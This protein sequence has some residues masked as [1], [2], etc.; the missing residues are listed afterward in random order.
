MKFLKAFVACATLLVAANSNAALINFNDYSIEGF[1]GQDVNGTST[2]SDFGLT[3]DLD[4]NT[5]VS[6]SNAFDFV[7][8]PTSVLYF[9][10]EAVGNNAELYGIGFDNDNRV[11]PSSLFAIGGTGNTRANSLASYQVGDGVVN[12]AINVGQFF[13]GSFEKMIFILDADEVNN[14]FASFSD[15]ELCSDNG[16]CETLNQSNVN[17]VNSPSASMLF[18]MSLCLL[19]LRIRR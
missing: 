12:F 8:D 7:I 3:L 13:T 19:G 1:A 6:I 17:V 16:L 11:T 9:S 2:V 4:G 15:V 10:F 5:W 14:T 18:L